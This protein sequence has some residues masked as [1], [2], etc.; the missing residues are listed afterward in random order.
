MSHNA[1]IDSCVF[2]AY[3]TE[4]EEFH[5]ACVTFFEQTECKKYTSKSVENELSRKMQKRDKLY[6]DY[7]KY[8]A[9][10]DNEEYKVSS[11]IYINE[12]DRRHLNDLIRHLSDISAH[13]QLTFLRQF[14]KRLKH[15]INKA[16]GFLEEVIPINNDV[17][18][19]DIIRSVIV[20]DFDSR[21]LNDA[22]QW[23]LSK[24]N[25]VFVT[26]DG[27]IYHNRGKLLQVVKNYKFL[28]ESPIQIIHGSIFNKS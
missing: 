3:G 2:I 25:V 4:F 5:S 26:F 23:S 10:G 24:D 8:L 1:F 9:R 18:F 12:N 21:I 11:D 19:K 6:Q 20:N 28:S 15:R 13:E 14:G 22:I 7:S 17:Y 16:I 27:E